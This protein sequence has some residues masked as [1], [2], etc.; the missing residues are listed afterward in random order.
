MTNC[1]LTKLP[2]DIINLS[3]RSKR[4]QFNCTFPIQS[5]IATLELSLFY[6]RGRQ[7]VFI[8]IFQHNS[9]T[10]KITHVI[11]GVWYHNLVV[12]FSH[13]H[14]NMITKYNKQYDHKHTWPYMSTALCLLVRRCI[15]FRSMLE[16]NYTTIFSQKTKFMV[17]VS[18]G[19]NRKK[20][21][22]MY[23][24]SPPPQTWRAQMSVDDALYPMYLKH[25]VSSMQT[26]HIH[27]RLTAQP[28][29]ADQP[30]NRYRNQWWSG[31]LKI[32]SCSLFIG[33]KF[34][35]SCTKNG[36]MRHITAPLQK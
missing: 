21:R 19:W 18:L 28:S 10:V 13:T 16:I 12:S 26:R 22:W 34:A 2:H 24:M 30:L 15:Y 29:S 14:K 4:N 17:K 7:K 33:V 27:R 6:K 32:W 36:K 25:L 35:V 31:V 20:A 8:T 11:L 9:A 23:D 1:A 5:D 3:N